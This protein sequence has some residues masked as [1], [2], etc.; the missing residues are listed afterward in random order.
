MEILRAWACKFPTA[1]LL[2]RINTFLSPPRCTV[3][4][5]LNS[6]VSTRTCRG[7][8]IMY[9][10]I[11]NKNTIVH[12]ILRNFD[13]TFLPSLYIEFLTNLSKG[14]F[15]FIHVVI[16]FFENRE[17]YDRNCKPREARS[18]RSRFNTRLFSLFERFPRI[19]PRSIIGDPF[20]RFG[21]RGRSFK[22]QRPTPRSNEIFRFSLNE[23]Y[24]SYD[25]IAVK[26][27]WTNER[28][29]RSGIRAWKVHCIPVSSLSLE[30]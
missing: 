23:R 21:A 3:I 16:R 18:R 26:C 20:L 11:A 29:L 19:E 7:L 6:S 1:K 14:S 10:N 22:R 9:R 2:G 12:N 8:L 15:T 27:V 4:R 30:M 28:C 17:N 24:R 13:N 25:T 5:S